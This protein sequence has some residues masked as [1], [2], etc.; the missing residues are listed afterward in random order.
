VG[1]GLPL[2][3]RSGTS[4]TVRVGFGLGRVLFGGAAGTFRGALLRRGVNE[5]H[6]RATGRPES[7]RA[8]PPEGGWPA[9]RLAS[10]ED[11]RG[12]RRVSTISLQIMINLRFSR[13]E[14][15]RR[16]AKA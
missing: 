16:Y 14:T 4:P 2:S 12:S 6:R 5:D 9:R 7:L 13:C 15:R 3:S 10:P 11:H 8:G 1:T